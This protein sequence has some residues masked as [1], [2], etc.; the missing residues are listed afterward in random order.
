MTLKKLISVY[1]LHR[2]ILQVVCTN[3][4]I[5]TKYFHTFSFKTLLHALHNE[6]KV[7]HKC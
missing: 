6:K 4:I 7:F 3:N 5:V 2:F 1:Y